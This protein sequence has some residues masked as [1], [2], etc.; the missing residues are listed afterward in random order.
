M[1][2]D[3]SRVGLVARSLSPSGS[4]HVLTSVHRQTGERPELPSGEGNGRSALRSPLTHCWTFCRLRPVR[5]A[6]SGT[7]TNSGSRRS[8]R[9][10][11][12]SASNLA[13]SFT[14]AS[15]AWTPLPD[16]ARRCTPRCHDIS[17]SKRSMITATDCSSSTVM[18]STTS[19]N[20]YS[21]SHLILLSSSCG[22]RRSVATLHSGSLPPCLLS[23]DNRPRRTAGIA[24]RQRAASCLIRDAPRRTA[25]VLRC[26]SDWDAST[27]RLAGALQRA[28][29]A[30]RAD[31]PA[32]FH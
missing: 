12:T 23:N 31:G 24:W 6:M 1:T 15:T 22:C 13:S 18:P 10:G 28:P 4:S 16:T 7:P 26:S 21:A 9:N 2:A 25:G 27:D 17:P 11:G 14:R 3:S 32:I 30:C 19:R 29:M 8:T 20:S 5:S